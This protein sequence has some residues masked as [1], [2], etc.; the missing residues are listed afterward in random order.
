MLRTNEKEVSSNRNYYGVPIIKKKS[1][2]QQKKK[3]NLRYV[4]MFSYYI[5]YIYAKNIYYCMW[6]SVH[7]LIVAY[8]NKGDE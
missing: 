8:V 4:F 2:K 7:I 1:T 3:K 5:T 6:Y